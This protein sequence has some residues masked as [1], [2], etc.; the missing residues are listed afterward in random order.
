M[1]HGRHAGQQ[2]L[3]PADEQPIAKRMRAALRGSPGRPRARPHVVDPAGGV[4]VAIAPL[5]PAVVI[6]LEMIVRVDQPGQHERAVEIDDT[7]AA[8]RRL[9]DRQDA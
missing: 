4:V 1:R 3:Q 7:I 9:A 6:Q 2:I 8:L 5:E